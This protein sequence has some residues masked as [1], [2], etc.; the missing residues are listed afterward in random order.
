MVKTPEVT[1][2]NKLEYKPPQGSIAFAPEL[3]GIIQ[4]GEKQSTYRYG[5]KY[6]YVNIGDM[7][8][9]VNSSTE[10]IETKV[11]IT[12]KRKTIFKDLPLSFDKHESYSDKEH[13]RQVLSGYYAYI[14][15]PIKDEEVFLIFEF[16]L[17]DEW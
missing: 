15:H 14:G 6:D 5:L 8:D 4:S 9:I 17:A 11:V 3:I 16:E 13:Q 7:V 12:A 2:V 10:Q 1:S